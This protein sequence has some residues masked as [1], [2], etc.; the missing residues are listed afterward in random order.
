MEEGLQSNAAVLAQL[1]K[2]GKL[3]KKMK[4]A[5][6]D[7]IF[8]FDAAQYHH[9]VR[10]VDYARVKVDGVRCRLLDD[11]PA[12]VDD[13][14]KAVWAAIT[15]VGGPRS[16]CGVVLWDCLGIGSPLGGRATALFSALAVLVKHFEGG[17]DDD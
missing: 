1:N 4:C 13:A 8:L 11:V 12:P 17:H 14:R 15:A 5:A 2:I 9:D 7:F 3:T 6:S 10:A 16:R